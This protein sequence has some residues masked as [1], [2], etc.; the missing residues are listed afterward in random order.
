MTTLDVLICNIVQNTGN[1]APG[2]LKKM[3]NKQRKAQRK[4]QE[5]KAQALAAQEKRDMHKNRQQVTNTSDEADAMPLD[6]LLPEKLERV[7]DPLEQ[8]I[9]FLKPL[10]ELASDNIETHL[11]A[12]EIY[13]RKDKLLLMLQSIKRSHRICPDHPMFHSCLIRFMEKL[14]KLDNIQEEMQ[15]VLN[16][17]LEPILGGMSAAEI[18]SQF[19]NKHHKSL[20]ALVQGL[21]MK[22][23]L[24]NS[25]QQEVLD[26]ITK[27]DDSL[28]NVNIQTCTD[29]LNSLINGEFGEVGDVAEEYRKT[30]YK[31]FPLA[32]AFHTDQDRSP[33]AFWSNSYKTL[34]ETQENCVSN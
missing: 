3:L 22:Y 14:L 4:A 34:N 19:L 23:K 32:T 13:Y 27:L 6:E 24:D 33:M 15:L 5:E 16:K 31:R 2:Q 17:Q 8:S 1:L 25:T 18:N 28:E 9:K 12:F 21:K 10:Q 20:P 7:E 30:C 29:I 26:Q 11:M